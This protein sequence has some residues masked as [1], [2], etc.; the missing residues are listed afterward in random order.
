MKPMYT[1]NFPDD[2]TYN[3]ACNAAL[4]MAKWAQTEANAEH[5]SP[6]TESLQIRADQ[7]QRVFR[8]LDEAQRNEP[9]EEPEC[10][11][12]TETFGH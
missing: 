2:D 3:L 9:L 10:N 12:A 11:G 6:Y 1:V 7:Y 4:H 8:I 5:N